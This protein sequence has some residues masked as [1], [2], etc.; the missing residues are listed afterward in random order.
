MA[1]ETQDCDRVQYR[2]LGLLTQNHGNLLVVGDGNQSIFAWRGASPSLFTNIEQ[3]FPD[4][5]KLYLGT[6]YRSTKKLVE[7]IKKIAPNATNFLTALT[8][9][10]KRVP[11]LK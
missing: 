3:T 5:R 6:N 2:L 8:L 4:I 1:D 7:F 11:N 10:M 9:Q